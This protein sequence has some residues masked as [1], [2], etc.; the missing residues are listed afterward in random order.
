MQVNALGQ[1]TTVIPTSMLFK[2][3]IYLFHIFVSN[4]CFYFLFVLFIKLQLIQN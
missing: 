4:D 3:K 1:P 2:A